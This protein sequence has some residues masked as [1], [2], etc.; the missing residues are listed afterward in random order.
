M[1]LL[2]DNYDSFTYNLWHYLLQLNEECIVKRIDEITIEEIEKLNPNAIVLSP[3]P[4][5]PEDSGVMNEV[6]KHFF[7]TIPIL[8][9]CLGHQAIGE[10]FGARLMH[11]E[12]P[13]H[14]KTS[15]LI[16]QNHILF[17]NILTPQLVMRYH[18]LL[19]KEVENTPLK[20]IATTNEH[21]IM[22]IE[23]PDYKI[24]GLQFH[25]E[26]ILTPDGMTILR[27]WW[28]SIGSMQ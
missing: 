21:E 3:G 11:A 7:K 20:I 22:A 4:G 12:T 5:K 15:E 1:I 25:P 10:F 18:S 24:T 8:G 6:I 23:H 9:I 13:M 2:L 26:S 28:K 19:L 16:F 14:G 27:N 17:Q